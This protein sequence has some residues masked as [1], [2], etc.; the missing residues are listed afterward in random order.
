MIELILVL[1]TFLCAVII[2]K[3]V[4]KVKLPAILG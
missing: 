4:S 3:L 2:G 1:V